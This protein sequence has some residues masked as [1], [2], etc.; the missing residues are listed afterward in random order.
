M[1]RKQN[2]SLSYLVQTNMGE[3]RIHAD[4]IRKRAIG[5]QEDPEGNEDEAAD[6]K[7]GED[8]NN[9][10]QDNEERSVGRDQQVVEDTTQQETKRGSIW[11]PSEVEGSMSEESFRTAND[12][13]NRSE[14][15]SEH[16]LNEERLLRRS[17]RIR[18]K[19]ILP[20]DEFRNLRGREM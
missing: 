17:S 12:Q 19:P 4:H 8:Q 18:R 14:N 15:K 6:L 16:E 13:A 2:G 11:E 7:D 5:K 1:I 3:K 10:L 20:Y 9:K